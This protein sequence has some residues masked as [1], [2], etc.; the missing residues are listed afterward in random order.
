MSMMLLVGHEE[1]FAEA[2]FRVR[3]MEV[4]SLVYDRLRF[5]LGIIGR[6]QLKERTL[7]YCIDTSRFQACN[8]KHTGI[9]DDACG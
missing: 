5:L 1:L 3:A 7:P 8:T 4:Q 2:G 6:E 9:Y